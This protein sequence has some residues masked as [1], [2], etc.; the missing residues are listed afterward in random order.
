MTP[1][2]SIVI[3]TYNRAHLLARAIK[4]VLTQT[5]QNIELIIV[6]DASA[7]NTEDVVKGFSDPR[8]H[9]IRHDQNRGCSAARNTG[10]KESKGEFVAL[11]DSDDEYLSEK[12]EESLK[13]FRDSFRN[14]GVV[15]SNYW[16]VVDGKKYVGV[17]RKM[18]FLY[19][20]VFSRD[21]FEK[22]GLFDESIEFCE[23]LDFF[24]R[25]VC[26]PF[27]T[28]FIDKPLAVYYFTQGSLCTDFK[29]ERSIEIKR[30]ILKK[31][32]PA[33]KNGLMPLARRAIARI[34]YFLG[35]D[36]LTV[37]R[38]MEARGYFLKAFYLDPMRIEYL[39][40]FLQSCCKS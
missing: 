15:A 10:I 20:G 12:I 13:V 8:V 25:L 38:P 30:T 40:K 14:L 22:I 1:L 27:A 18:P 28:H 3:P 6:D 34:N 24:M 33:I 31:C 37:G 23:D 19:F 36:F 5:Y 16:R 2:V 4:S 11:L 32:T 26:Y 7:D 35:K 29:M 9:Y 21:V 17:S 39:G